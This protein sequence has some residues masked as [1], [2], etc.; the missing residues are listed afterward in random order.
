MESGVEEL[1]VAKLLP[2]A[3]EK[4]FQALTRTVDIGMW[5][6]LAM[7]SYGG[8]WIGGAS[9][10]QVIAICSWEGL[11]GPDY[12]KTEIDETTQKWS[13]LDGVL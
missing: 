5:S 13:L 7:I 4:G 10:C 8:V 3:I 2:F 6:E 12:R 11:P 1:P 9:N